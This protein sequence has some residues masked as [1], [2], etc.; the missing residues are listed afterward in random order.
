MP[1]RWLS[2]LPDI[3]KMSKCWPT[4]KSYFQSVGEDKCS[5]LIWK[6]TED[7]SREKDYSTTEMYMPFFQNCLMIFEEA[8]RSLEKDKLSAPELFDVMYELQQKLLQ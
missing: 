8:I 1:T 7:E 3:E 2:P 5:S 4:V 6:Y